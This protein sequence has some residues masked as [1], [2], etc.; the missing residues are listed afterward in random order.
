MKRILVLCFIFLVNFALIAEAAW[1]QPP[2]TYKALKNDTWNSIAKKFEIPVGLLKRYNSDKKDRNVKINDRISIP[3]KAVYVIK[4]GESTLK[5]ALSNGMTFSELIS[6]NNIIDPDALKPRDKLKIIKA[7]TSSKQKK[8]KKESISSDI[9]LI[10]PINGE[11][12]KKFG[13]Q[14]NGSHNNEIAIVSDETEVKAAAPGMVVYTGDEVGKRGNL[15]ILQHENNWFT[16]YG[17]LNTIKVQKGDVVQE[18]KILGE[19]FSS[20]PEIK[21]EL[22]FGLRLG[23]SAVNPTKHFKKRKA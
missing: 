2:F 18:G 1:E 14:I 6:I 20:N 5:I 17:N 10:W 16:S 15:I 13:R 7:K 4:Q 3:E 22:F 21:P 9:K 12:T 23:F 8:M 11:I 19:I